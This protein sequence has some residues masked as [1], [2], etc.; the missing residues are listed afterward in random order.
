MLELILHGGHAIDGS[1]DLPLPA[2]VD[3]LERDFRIQDSTPTSQP[4]WPLVS[5]PVTPTLAALMLALKAILMVPEA[6]ADRS[7]ANVGVTGC[8]TSGQIG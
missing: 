6:E 4:I 3:Q 7:A 8:D 1:P 2:S 5:Q